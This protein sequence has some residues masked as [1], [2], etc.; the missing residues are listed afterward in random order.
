MMSD[1]SRLM[2]F[3]EKFDDLLAPFDLFDH[4]VELIGA[5]IFPGGRRIIIVIDRDDD[6]KIK[7]YTDFLE[8]GDTLT[9][10]MNGGGPPSA[11]HRYKT[12]N[13]L[14]PKK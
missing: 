1:Y 11:I 7:H 9:L 6:N 12:T 5:F 3:T 14:K 13:L 4:N 8:P 10:V 2:E